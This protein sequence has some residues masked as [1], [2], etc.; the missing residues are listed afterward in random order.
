MSHTTEPSLNN[1]ASQLAESALL[2]TRDHKVT[3]PGK[4]AL[5]WHPGLNQA[6]TI[7]QLGK[8]LDG[9][10]GP[11]AGNKDLCFTV[12][13]LPCGSGDTSLV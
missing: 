4:Q 1:L 7:W 9:P 3:E 12:A 8:L 2:H 13:S 5:D 10:P 11:E 6:P